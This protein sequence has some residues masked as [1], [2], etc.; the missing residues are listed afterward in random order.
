M[1]KTFGCY[2]SCFDMWC[3]NEPGVALLSTD[4]HLPEAS[5]IFGGFIMF[6]MARRT[7]LGAAI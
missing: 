2:G 6:D 4:K 3:L 1:E 5:N 7:K